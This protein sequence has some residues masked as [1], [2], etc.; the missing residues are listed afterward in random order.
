MLSFESDY[1]QGCHEKILQALAETNYDKEPGYGADRF[2]RSAADRIRK[3][4][5]CD[6]AEVY[7]ISGGTQTNQ[8]TIDTM[9]DSHEGVIAA[10]TGHIACHEAGAI[11][12]SGHKVLELPQENG[13][14]DPKDLEHLMET[15]LG[16]ESRDHLVFPGMVYLSQ[17]TE[18]GTL[19][20]EKELRDI[21]TLCDRYDLRLYIDGARLGYGLAA[22]SN[23]VTLPILAEVCDAFYIGGT[24]VGALC[25]EALVFPRKSPKHFI[26]KV[27]QHGAMLAK[28][29]LIG[30]QFDTLFKDDLYFEISRHA[31]TMAQGI[32]DAF[33]DF[34]YSFHM[35][36]V[37]NQVFVVL[38]EQQRKTLLPHLRFSFWERLDPD[39]I[40]VRLAASWATTP[41][42]VSLLRQI[43][44]Q[45]KEEEPC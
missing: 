7:F 13:K 33:A 34:G 40:V 29:R 16:D 11:E 43:L 10:K 25:G 1:I 27:K 35:P 44:Q 38:T 4:C 26:T 2:S 30:I 17:P 36:L 19:Y 37:S 39:R 20:S 12:Y 45:C 18:Y 5:H 6:T 31:M 23:D 8:L 15:F 24:K 41:E 42:D 21:R 28:G 14:I 32:R 3:A 22:P 9:L